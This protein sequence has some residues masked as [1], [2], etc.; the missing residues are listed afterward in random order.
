ML[1]LI[2]FFFIEELI[3]YVL[4]SDLYGDLY[5][6]YLARSIFGKIARLGLQGVDFLL[7]D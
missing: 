1:S 7:V 3:R 6:A 5:L 2:Y 4:A